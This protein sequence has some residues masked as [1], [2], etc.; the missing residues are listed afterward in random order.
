MTL[1]HDKYSVPELILPWRF[2][3]MDLK[4]KFRFYNVECFR[5]LIDQDYHVWITDFHNRIA[6]HR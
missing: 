6:D 1:E 5:P 2:Y 3:E 4:L